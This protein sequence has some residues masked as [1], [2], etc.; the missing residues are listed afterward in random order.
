MKIREFF[1]DSEAFVFTGKRPVRS[2]DYSIKWIDKDYPELWSDLDREAIQE[3]IKYK[4]EDLWFI[5]D[6]LQGGDYSGNGL[7]ARSNCDLILE[8]I[9]ERSNDDGLNRK[10]VEILGSHGSFG[11]AIRG[12]VDDEELTEMLSSISDYPVLD[13]EHHNLLEL[14]AQQEAWDNWVSSDFVSELEKKFD[15]ELDDFEED[16]LFNIFMNTEPEWINETGD[17]MW[18][19]V[20]MAADKVEKCQIENWIVNDQSIE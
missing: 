14:N 9:G 4:D 11:I 3:K 1:N 10:I 17:S 6:Y 20:K 2:F 16:H 18:V 13:D 19:N 5:H 8:W 7:I 12:D 15:V